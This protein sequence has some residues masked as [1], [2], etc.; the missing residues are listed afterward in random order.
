[1]SSPLNVE[2]NG[3]AFTADVTECVLFCI[4][5]FHLLQVFGRLALLHEEPVVR[6]LRRRLPGAFQ[7]V[8]P[9]RDGSE[10]GGRRGVRTRFS[11]GGR[12]YVG[13]APGNAR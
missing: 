13:P 12:G 10:A 8:L 6:E 11:L 2:T 5:L 1:M 9:P 4:R 3:K 7:Q